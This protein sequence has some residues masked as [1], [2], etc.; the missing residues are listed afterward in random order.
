MRRERNKQAAARCRK[1]RLDHTMALQQVIIMPTIFVETNANCFFFIPSI[2]NG[3]VGR[4][5][6]NLAE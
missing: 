4:Q 6:T 5:E 3:V 1:R 2:G